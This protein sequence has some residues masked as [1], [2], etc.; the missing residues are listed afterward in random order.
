MAQ[1]GE[2]I[3]LLSER[4]KW[5]DSLPV[6]L[7][8]WHFWAGL[9][10]CW[11]QER[12]CPEVASLGCVFEANCINAFIGDM[13]IHV[14]TTVV[15]VSSMWE[16]PGWSPLTKYT[17]LWYVWYWMTWCFH[18]SDLAPKCWLK[19][20]NVKSIELTCEDFLALKK[21][22][23]ISHDWSWIIWKTPSQRSWPSC[24]QSFIR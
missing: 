17:Q 24:V 15:S 16:N 10:A 9:R 8:S 3:Q 22:L 20:S 1:L 21:P 13:W 14:I 4:V 7:H 11:C 5:A 2:F 12:Q 6:S 23:G 18:D 19:L